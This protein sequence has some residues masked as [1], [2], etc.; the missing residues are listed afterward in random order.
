MQLYGAIV[1]QH[2]QKQD[3][4]RVWRGVV[5]KEEDFVVRLIRRLNLHMT[6]PAPELARIKSNLFQGH[7]LVVQTMDGT[8]IEIIPLCCPSRMWRRGKR[9]VDLAFGQ[10]KDET[11]DE[12][13]KNH[14]L[15]RPKE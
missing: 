4:L 2:G 14:L 8:V 9:I 10:G 12:V 7:T 15:F 3:M 6:T 11:V 1:F 5:E 13:L